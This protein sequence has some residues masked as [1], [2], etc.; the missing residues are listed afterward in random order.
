MLRGEASSEELFGQA[1]EI[2]A[3]DCS[4]SADGRGRSTT[5]ATSPACSRRAPCAG[6][7]HEPWV[8]R[9]EHARLDRD[10]RRAGLPRDRA[11]AAARPLHPRD[12]WPDGDALGVRHLELRRLRRADGRSAGQVLHDPGGDV[13]GARDPHGRVARGRWSTRP[14][15]A[16]L[17]RDARAPV[18]VLHARHADDRPRAAG[19]EPDPTDQEIRTAISARSAAARGTRTSSERFAGLPSTKPPRD[20]GSEHGHG[21]ESPRAARPSVRSASAA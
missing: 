21:R 1:G 16:G 15:P 13:R 9:P 6:R 4:P 5:S 3:A 17:P 7:R 8:R 2:A 14:G 11:A 12:A 20:R 18:R 19:R 10:Q